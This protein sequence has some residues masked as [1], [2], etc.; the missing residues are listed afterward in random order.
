MTEEEVE[1]PKEKIAA[2][3]AEPGEATKQAMLDL[4][5]AD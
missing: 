5:V 3:R 1:E 4:Q 2:E